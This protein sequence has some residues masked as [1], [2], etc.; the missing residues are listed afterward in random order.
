MRSLRLVNYKG[1]RDH[2]I[3]FRQSNVL[4][5]ANNAGKSTALGALRLLAAMVP[6]ARRVRPRDSGEVDGRV[7]AGWSITAAAIDNSAFA[8]EN[9]RHDFSPLETRIELA[10]TNGVRLVASWDDVRDSDEFDPP[11]SGTFFVFPPDGQ[12][13]TQPRKAAQELVPLIAIVP[14]LTPLDDRER[15]ISDETLRRHQTSRRSSRYFRNAL[16]RLSSEEWD[17]FRSYVYERTP[18]ISNL[19]L[20]RAVGTTEDDFDLFYEEEGTR[21][22]REIAWAGDG[23]QIWIQALFHIWKQSGAAV[24][25]L[26]EP[27]VFLHPDLQRRLAR[28]VFAT[29]QQA[30]LATHSVEILAEA[31]PGSAVWVDR[32]RRSAERPK[33]GGGPWAN[34]AP[35]RKRLRTRRWASPEEQFGS[36]R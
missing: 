27:D 25:L 1:F 16:Y 3:S 22:E 12:R 19:G 11:P 31:E 2:T 13:I 24:I 9:I 35:P 28:A 8:H 14:T 20:H 30:V 26:D 7:F 34:G 36:V 5:G 29:G 21:R 18:E 6:T 32:S 15:Y 33:S 23:I 4:V 10:L 17:E